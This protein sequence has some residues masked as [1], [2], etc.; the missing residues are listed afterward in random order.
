MAQSDPK[1]EELRAHAKTGGD[2]A[3]KVNSGTSPRKWLSTRRSWRKSWKRPNTWLALCKT[4][5]SSRYALPGVTALR[6]SVFLRE[7]AQRIKHL[8]RFLAKRSLIFETTL[9]R[10]IVT[11]EWCFQRE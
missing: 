7:A 11:P 1:A 5:S 10:I 2:V 4:F 3:T 9:H 8:S 6:Q